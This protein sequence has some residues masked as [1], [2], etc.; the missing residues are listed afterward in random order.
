MS[1]RR[2]FEQTD[3]N[4]PIRYRPKELRKVASL[5][6]ARPLSIAKPPGVRMMAKD[7]QKPP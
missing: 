5:I 6:S 2:D 4:Q 3:M 1:V 7:S